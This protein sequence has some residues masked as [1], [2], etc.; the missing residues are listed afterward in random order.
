MDEFADIVSFCVAPCVFVFIFYSQDT[1]FLL[2]SIIFLIF[3]MLHLVNYHISEK[4]YF[5]GLTTPASAIMITSLAYLSFPFWLI[6]IFFIVLAILMVFPILYPRIEKHF[7]A[8][9]C[10]IIFLAMMRKEFV[11]LLLVSTLIYIII[12]PLYV[13]YKMRQLPL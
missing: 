3:G 12:G 6:I 11:F 10:I 7:A 2:P 9:A 1:I 4:E 13:I 8:I 5:I